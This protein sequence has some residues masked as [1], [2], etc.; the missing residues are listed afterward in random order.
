MEALAGSAKRVAASVTSVWV[1]L[2]RK[3]Y[4]R[5]LFIRTIDVVWCNTEII[6]TKFAAKQLVLC[7]TTTSILCLTRPAAYS[8]II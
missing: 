1:I 7:G 3:P 2:V 8:S 4:S 6:I 5:I